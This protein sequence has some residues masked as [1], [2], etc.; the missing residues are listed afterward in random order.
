VVSARAFVKAAPAAPVEPAPGSS[1]RLKGVKVLVTDDEASARGLM[2]QVLVSEGADVMTASSAKE[3]VA[4]CTRWRPAVLVLDIGMP[5][6]DGYA[7]LRN[8]RGKGSAPCGAPAI[9][10]TGYARD[11]D[12]ERALSAGFEAHVTKPYDIEELVKLIGSLARR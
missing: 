11:E 12:R 3:A 6:E 1:S 7:L 10:V 4:I 5:G 8:L 2:S 9:A